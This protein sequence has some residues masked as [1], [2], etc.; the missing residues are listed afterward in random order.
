MW[1]MAFK[2]ADYPHGTFVVGEKL[3]VFG[4]E[5]TILAVTDHAVKYYVQFDGE[6]HR[7]DGKQM[8]VLR[9]MVSYPIRLT[10]AQMETPTN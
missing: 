5:H 3:T 10:K 9:T 8:P 4:H 6:C 1:T 2:A 7:D